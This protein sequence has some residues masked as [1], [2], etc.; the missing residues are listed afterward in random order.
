MNLI[1]IID[2][3][4]WI[5]IQSAIDDER[6]LWLWGSNANVNYGKIYSAPAPSTILS[7]LIFCFDVCWNPSVYNYFLYR[8]KKLKDIPTFQLFIH[9]SHSWVSTLFQQ[10]LVCIKPMLIACQVIL[11]WPIAVFRGGI[12]WYNHDVV[13]S[14]WLNKKKGP[15]SP[16]TLVSLVNLHFKL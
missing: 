5:W 13:R 16:N 14:W 10:N 12:P 4:Y 11:F 7:S 8:P 9:C 2:C 3:Y 15:D 1:H 6:C